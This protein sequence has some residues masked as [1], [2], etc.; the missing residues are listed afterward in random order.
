MHAALFVDRIECSALEN[1]QDIGALGMRRLAVGSSE[2]QGGRYNETEDQMPFRHGDSIKS[3]N[4]SKAEA[5]PLLEIQFES[6]ST[7]SG[8]SMSSQ[9][10]RRTASRRPVA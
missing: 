3:K 7:T 6:P 9:A 1:A 8:P 5:N 10:I 2:C 4:M